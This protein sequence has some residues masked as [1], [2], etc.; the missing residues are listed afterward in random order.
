VSFSDDLDR[1]RAHVMRAVRQA[2]SSCQR[3]VR[4]RG[5]RVRL[6]RLLGFPATAGARVP[7]GPPI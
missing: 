1:Q 3:L 4:F 5:L 7:T 6:I 2:G